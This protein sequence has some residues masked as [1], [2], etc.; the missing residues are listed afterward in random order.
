[1]EDLPIS[2]QNGLKEGFAELPQKVLWKLESDI[3]MVNQPKNVF[4]RKWYPQYDIIREHINLIIIRYMKV[5]NT[6]FLFFR[7]QFNRTTS[8][9]IINLHKC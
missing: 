3:P 6:F 9:E 4:T 2:I 8:I 1:M 5:W 7:T